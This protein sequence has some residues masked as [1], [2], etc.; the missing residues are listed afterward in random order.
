MASLAALL[1]AISLAP[2]AAQA[3]T[4]PAAPVVSN[5]G[6]TISWPTVP[7]AEGHNIYYNNS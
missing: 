2:A 7:T 4:K 5:S 3:A 1:L 6:A